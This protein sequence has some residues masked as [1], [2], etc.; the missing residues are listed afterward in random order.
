MFVVLSSRA[1]PDSACA[2]SKGT[3]GWNRLRPCPPSVWRPPPLTPWPATFL[4]P[5]SRR[6]VSLA[7]SRLSSPYPGAL[8]GVGGCGVDPTDNA[9][10]DAEPV[11]RRRRPF[12]HADARTCAPARPWRGGGGGCLR[13]NNRFGVSLLL[14]VGRAAAALPRVSL[15]CGGRPQQLPVFFSFFSSLCRSLLRFVRPP[16]RWVAGGGVRVRPCGARAASTSSR[17]GRWLRCTAVPPPPPPRPRPTPLFPL[18]LPPTLH[19]RTPTLLIP[20]PLSP[21]PFSRRWGW[22]DPRGRLRRDGRAG[23]CDQ[24]GGGD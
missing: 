15:G 1:G 19:A 10:S 23:V 3:L 21:P 24:R 12:R 6:G 9:L 7:T 14:G 13:L 17:S 16:A 11:R 5:Q 2:W 4:I 22:H 20:R 18:A 8:S